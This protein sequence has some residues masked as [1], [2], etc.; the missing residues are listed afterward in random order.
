MA[1]DKYITIRKRQ[2]MLTAGYWNGIYQT[3]PLIKKINGTRAEKMWQIYRGGHLEQIHSGKSWYKSGKVISQR[4]FR[5]KKYFLFLKKEIEKAERKAGYFSK[6]FNNQDLRKFSFKE[7]IKATEQIKSL[8]FNYDVFN[9]PA[10]FWGGDR[11]RELVKKNLRV[12]EAKFLALSTPIK[13]TFVSQ[14]EFDLLSAVV[15]IKNKESNFEKIAIKLSEK[16]GWIPFGYD[17]PEYWGK[18]YFIKEIKKNYSNAEKKLKMITESDKQN[19][20]QRQEI[21]KNYK[22]DKKQLEL[23][24]RLNYLA[25]WTDERKR[26]TFGLSYCYSK[27]LWEF[28]RRLKIPYI[29]L[30]YLLTEELPLLEN[31]KEEL[32]KLS[33]QRIKNRI[34]TEF[35]NGKIKFLTPQEQEDFLKN[36][37]EEP[38]VGI[39][40]GFVAS[41]GLKEKYRGRVKVLFTPQDVRKIKTGDFIVASMTTPDYILAMKKASG[42][43]TDEGGITCHAAIVAR[44]M[45]KPCIIGTKIA[46]QIFKDGDLVEV[47]AER[48][49]VKKL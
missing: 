44:E 5:D 12:P 4:L 46:T 35:K 7:L 3:S 48:G 26:T 37:K 34:T 9:V 45:K 16:Y 49:I 28:E 29:N 8:W 6:K 41:K 14:L 38:F 10:W 32:L 2:N 17:G 33:E 20:K 1:G 23:I 21:I 42:F 18:E 30:K 27:V 24:D 15:L 36:I 22:L 25:L 39:I 19:L 31:Q 40:K 13:K 11:F 47:D 43:I